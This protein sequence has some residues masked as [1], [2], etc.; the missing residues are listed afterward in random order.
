MS[1]ALK[2]KLDN[3]LVPG[4]NKKSTKWHVESDSVL[5]I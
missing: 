5:Q 4:E 2:G 3:S 1:C